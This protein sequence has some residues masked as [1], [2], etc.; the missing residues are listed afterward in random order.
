MEEQVWVDYSQSRNIQLRNKLVE[1]NLALVHF[2]VK[3]HHN[4]IFK[5]N[6][7]DDL[8]SYGT[9]GLIKAVEKYDVTLKIKFSTFAYQKIYYSIID[10]LR[11]EDWV[12]RS[13]RSKIKKARSMM[14]DVGNSIDNTM[15]SYII[16]K[17]CK[18]SQRDMNVMNGTILTSIDNVC[19]EYKYESNKTK[20]DLIYDTILF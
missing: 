18:L 8:Y 17:D 10:G 1:N 14:Q 3:K 2:I 5:G 20:E 16:A 4:N 13:V 7:Y 19:V 11:S 12:P 6:E 9:I 15:H